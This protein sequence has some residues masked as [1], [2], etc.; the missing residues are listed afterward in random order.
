MDFLNQGFKG[1]SIAGDVTIAKN[2]VATVEYF[3]LKGKEDSDM[4]AKTL[5][6]QL[7]VTF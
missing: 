4:K 1:W 2:M 3:D 5:W 7:A 6:S